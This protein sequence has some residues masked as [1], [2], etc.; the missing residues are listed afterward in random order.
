M[1]FSAKFGV[2]AIAAVAAGA[3]LFSADSISAA[4]TGKAAIEARQDA[5]KSLGKDNKAVQGFV[6]DGK[7]SAADV[8]KAA[9]SMAAAAKKLPSLFPKGSGR[10]DFSDKETRADPKIWSDWAGFEKAAG[11][12]AAESTKLAAVAKTGDKGA[13][14]KQVGKLGCGGCHDTYR[15]EKA[16]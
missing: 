3:A 6:K 4:M 13:I 1:G 10:G 11:V 7:G 14:A 16:K 12:L 9:M 5:M 2:V 15:G 8:E